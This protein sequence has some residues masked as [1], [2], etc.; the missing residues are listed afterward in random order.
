MNDDRKCDTKIDSK[1]DVEEWYHKKEF[2]DIAEWRDPYGGL[3]S[4]T[5]RR[6]KKKE[7]T[8]VLDHH[9]KWKKISRTTW[10]VLELRK[11]WTQAQLVTLWAPLNY[12]ILAKLSR[13]VNST[14]CFPMATVKVTYTFEFEMHFMSV[15]SDIS[16]GTENQLPHIYTNLEMDVLIICQRSAT[17]LQPCWDSCSLQWRQFQ[18]LKTLPCPSES[19]QSCKFRICSDDW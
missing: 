18:V 11:G 15:S 2:E 13:L 9:I 19:K 14:I 8:H 12:D 7:I 3:A 5:F 1:Y 17:L 10:I 16:N 6:F 4:K